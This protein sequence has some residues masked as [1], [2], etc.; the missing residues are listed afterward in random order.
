MRL[1]RSR[2]RGTTS[3][4]CA[5]VFPV[6]LLLVFAVII[7]G[8]GVFRY[9]EVSSLA[10]EAARYASVRGEAYTFATGNAT[11]TPQEIYEAVIKPRAAALDLNR[12]TYSVTWEPSTQQGSAVR[13]TVTY[14]WLPEAFLGGMDLS[15]TACI[16]VSY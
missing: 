3:L 5:L 11:P 1:R 15:S 4:E 10:R 2:R 7:G 9:L 8:L 16:P 12:L 6:F 13:V 14:R